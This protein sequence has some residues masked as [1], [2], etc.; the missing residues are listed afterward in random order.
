MNEVKEFIK[1][2][3][4]GHMPISIKTIMDQFTKSPYGYIDLDVKWLAAKVFKDGLVTATV[5]KEPITL[6]NRKPEELTT[7]FTGKKYQEKILFLPKDEIEP[8]YLKAAKDVSKDLFKVTVTTTDADRLQQD[9]KTQ[10]ARLADKCDLYLERASTRAEYP[11]KP[12]LK[13]A[14][15]KMNVLISISDQKAFFKKI[16]EMKGEFQDL[17]EDL[18]PV[19]NFYSNESQRKIFNDYGLR[20]ISFYETSKEHIVNSKLE[21]TIGKIKT[22]VKNPKPYAL[23][24][25][26]PS[27]YEEFIH[28]Y[29][30]VLDEKAG[31]VKKRI[32]QDRDILLTHIDNNPAEEK[33]R[34]EITEKF[35]AFLEDVEKAND[36]SVMLGYKDK[37]DSL[38]NQYFNKFDNEAVY[39]EIPEGGNYGGGSVGEGD[40]EQ[41]VAPK[42]K[43]VVNRNAGELQSEWRI[44]SE[45]DLENYIRAFREQIAELIE[46]GKI[47]KIHF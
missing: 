2:S 38:M 13:H 25:N 9:L 32:E 46:E 45:Q 24:K 39:P 43:T 34:A 1:N 47:I 26:L 6:Y 44:E 8:Q 37:A 27:L 15:E 22:I 18:D 10:C 5:D 31:P 16:Y 14:K 23:I 40:G 4:L 12:E 11:G 35:N 28:I 36:I 7:Y 29:K 41:P 42:K 20:A 21:E 33:Y 3:T 19:L 17:A 30:D